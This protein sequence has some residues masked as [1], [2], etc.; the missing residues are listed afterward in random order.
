MSFVFIRVISSIVAVAALTVL[1][2]AATGEVP[3]SAS[4][5]A[6]RYRDA[7][8]PRILREYSEFLA[9]PNLARDTADIERNATYIRGQMQAA[10]V[11]TELL[12]VP[13]APPIVFGALT[14]PGA[15]RTLGI[16]AH[17]DGQPVDLK[18]W[19]HPPFEPNVYSAAV[20]AGGKPRALPKD[21]EP[22]DPNGASTRDRPATTRRRS[23]RSSTFSRRSAM[24]ACGPPPI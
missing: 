2:G 6:A 4:D 1:T 22:V 10:G 24:A 13:D 20:E 7:N 9:L 18:A 16:Y 19:R 3:Q 8:A 14:V 17:Y 12:R 15:T 5:V 11:T 23:P 21:G